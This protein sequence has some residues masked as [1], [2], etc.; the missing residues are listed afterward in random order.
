M[1]KAAAVLHGDSNVE[2]VVYFIQETEDSPTTIEYEITGLDPNSERGLSIHT[3]GDLTN[4][5]RSA[6]PHFNPYGKTHGAPGDENRHVGDLGN[7]LTAADGVAKG[8]ITD[9][10]VALIGPNSVLGRMIVIHAG[11]DD[12]GRGGHAD[13]LTTGN[14]GGR[15][16]GGVIGISQ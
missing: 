14:A 10:V 16:A 5:P 7:V 11:T 6:G 3:F 9:D 12:L 15:L 13:S 2:G 8:T 4:G 1:V